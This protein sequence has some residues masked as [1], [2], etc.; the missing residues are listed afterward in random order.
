MIL[1]LVIT[2]ENIT[3]IPREATHEKENQ[4]Y[5]IQPD[6]VKKKEKQE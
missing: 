5:K 6:R 1:K 2:R 4:N 3:L